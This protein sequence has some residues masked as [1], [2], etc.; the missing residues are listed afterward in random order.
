MQRCRC[1]AR[2]G[3]RVAIPYEGR[4]PYGNLRRPAAT[5]SPSST[6]NPSSAGNPFSA[7]RP[8]VVVMCMGLDSAKE[9]MDEYGTASSRAASRRAPSTARARKK[10]NTISRCAPSTGNP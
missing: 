8:P 7:A 10:A 9:E 3:R 2:Q 5:G 4:Q 1:R 6:G